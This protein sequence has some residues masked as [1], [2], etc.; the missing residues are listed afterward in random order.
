MRR[1]IVLLAVAAVAVASYPYYEDRRDG[2]L[3]QWMSRERWAPWGREVR[4]HVY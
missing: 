3:K 4:L 1:V 2:F